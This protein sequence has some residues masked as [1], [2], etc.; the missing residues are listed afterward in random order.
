MHCWLYLSTSKNLPM[1]RWPAPGRSIDFA[2]EAE[3]QSLKASSPS[4]PLRVSVQNCFTL[5]FCTNSSLLYRS[6]ADAITWQ[7]KSLST[8]LKPAALKLACLRCYC[9]CSASFMNK[10]AAAAIPIVVKARKCSQHL[11]H[12]CSSMFPGCTALPVPQQ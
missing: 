11:C 8:S 7:A 5:R 6:H 1:G 9:L 4:I 10:W 12:L 3:L 2:A